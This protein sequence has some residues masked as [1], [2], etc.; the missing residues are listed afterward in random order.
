MNNFLSRMS[1]RSQILSI[2]VLG[3]IGVVVLAVVYMIGSEDVRRQRGVADAATHL[4]HLIDSVDK[5]L[6]EAR[7]AEKDFFLRG[8]EALATRHKSVI[9]KVNATLAEAEKEIA[10]SPDLQANVDRLKSGLAEYVRHFGAAVE[11]K[12]KL[13]YDN[14]S[15][16]QGTLFAAT[17]TI[18]KTLG[19]HNDKNITVLMLVMRR[20][21]YGG[22]WVMPV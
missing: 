6:L 3:I 16:L 13:G 19:E 20:A 9:D 11:V 18:E 14:Q 15:G 7:I 21:S 1:L 5:D 22:K 10:S 12:R 17:E 2:G 8:S 4:E